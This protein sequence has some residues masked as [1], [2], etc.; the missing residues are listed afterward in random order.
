[1]A[2]FCLTRMLRSMVLARHG[3]AS[4]WPARLACGSA[5]VRLPLSLTMRLQNALLAEDWQSHWMKVA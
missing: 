5:R 3:I 4:P 2:A 1:M